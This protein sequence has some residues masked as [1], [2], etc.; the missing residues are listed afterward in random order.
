MRGE[1]TSP[2]GAIVAETTDGRLQRCPDAVDG[3]AA[4]DRGVPGSCRRRDAD[5]RR[6][7]GL[8]R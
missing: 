8:D 3:V 4:E 7:P 5:G 6:Y 2:D 1:A